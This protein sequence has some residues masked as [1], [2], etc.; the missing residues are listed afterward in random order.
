MYANVA[1]LTDKNVIPT[2]FINN[3]GVTASTKDNKY[4]L[5]IEINNMF[6]ALAF[7]EFKLQKPGRAVFMKL[8]YFLKY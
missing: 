1:R 7:D 2:Q 6:N 8:R 5:S 4:N 3:I